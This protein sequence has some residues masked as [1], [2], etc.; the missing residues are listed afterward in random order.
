MMIWRRGVVTAVDTPWAG[1]QEL[2]VDL[3]EPVGTGTTTVRA[4]GYLDTVGAGRVGDAVI[5]TAAALSRGLGTGGYAF[6]VAYPD[7]LPPDPE[8]A[9]GHI[10]KA[11]YTPLQTLR[12][13][14]DE[15]DSPHH[16]TLREADD[17]G[18]LPVIVADLHSAL[19]AIIAGL[20]S[21]NPGLSVAY[22]MTDGGALPLAFS[23]T[24]AELSAAG[25]VTTTITV[26]QAYGGQLEAVNIH[27]GLLA[28]A[29]IARADVAIVAQGPGN[30][31]TG[32]RWGF[33]GTSAGEALNAAGTLGG[34]PIGSLR[35]SGADPRPRHRGISHHS[36]TV[37]AK[38]AL[39][40]ITVVV[41]DLPGDLGAL[42]H[43]QV[44][45]GIP[46]RHRVVTEGVQGLTQ[47]LAGSPVPLSTMGRGLRVD[48]APFLAAAAA[49]RY[50]ARMLG[51]PPRPGTD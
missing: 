41:P 15:Q 18:G 32:T 36:M 34:V 26:G 51:V 27:T 30:L 14:V 24:L 17:L 10:V 40:P 28:A 50:T 11:R 48:A 38:V 21:I 35:V 16:E 6:V 31:G 29:Q 20:R 7:R 37:Y 13:G 45:S 1:V 23:R 49:G 8:P 19:P 9:P 25:W 33:S 4:L 44:A 22:V 39:V 5:L 12:L 46:P 2:H 43:S 47:A 42:V 3:T